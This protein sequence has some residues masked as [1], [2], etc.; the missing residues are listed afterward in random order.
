MSAKPS[1][2]QPT[3]EAT[4]TPPDPQIGRGHP[5]YHFVQSLL[6]LQQSI[7]HLTGTVE[8][9]EKRLDRIDDRFDEVEKQLSRINMI[10]FAAGVVL[11]IIL[12]VSG[13]T[14][15]KAWDFMASHIEIH[16]K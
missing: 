12:G 5:E 7:G 16:T 8:R 13:F 15:D 4:Q 10:L 14:I 9:I 6:S 1:D 3:P 11:A 2:I